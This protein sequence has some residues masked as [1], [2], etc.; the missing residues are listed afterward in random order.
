MN[1][2]KFNVINTLE[3]SIEKLAI[4][5]YLDAQTAPVLEEAIQSVVDEKN[6]IF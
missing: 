3:G 5:G 1:E 4:K 6:L 2:E